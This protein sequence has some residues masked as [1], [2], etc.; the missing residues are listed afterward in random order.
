MS[1]P[2]NSASSKPN[3]P[4]TTFVT[5]RRASWRSGT[6]PEGARLPC[7]LN[8]E[9]LVTK[10]CGAPFDLPPRLDLGEGLADLVA[11]LGQAH[12]AENVARRSRREQLLD[13]GEVS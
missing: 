6:G 7:S 11:S 3:E 9:T 4:W 8:A 5:C 10:E 13:G 1:G 2:C 12:A